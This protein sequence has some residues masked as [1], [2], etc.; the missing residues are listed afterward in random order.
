MAPIDQVIDVQVRSLMDLPNDVTPGARD[1]AQL[2]AWRTA[3][4]CALPQMVDALARLRNLKDWKGGFLIA[5]KLNFDWK[6]APF[7]R[8]ASFEEFYETELADTY[9]DLERLLDTA[10][11]LR[12]GEIDTGQALKDVEQSAEDTRAKKAQRHGLGKRV[13]KNG[14]PLRT[15]PNFDFIKVNHGGTSAAYLAGRLRRDRPDIADRLAAGEFPSVR[16]ACREAGIVKDKP[17]NPEADAKRILAL[18]DDYARAVSR[19][20]LQKLS[21]IDAGTGA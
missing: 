18:G 1:V 12:R 10:R 19:V 20:L 5:D 21:E 14:R 11:R 7:K 6:T 4:V 2:T 17:P 3:Q 9:G 16:A 8:Y 15:E 13:R